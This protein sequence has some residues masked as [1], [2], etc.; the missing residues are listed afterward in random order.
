MMGVC[1]KQIRMLAKVGFVED[2]KVVK[3]PESR[4]AHLIRNGL[5]EEAPEIHAKL[6]KKTTTLK[7]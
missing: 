2:G 4:A 1:M 7:D 6:K 5:A 3:V